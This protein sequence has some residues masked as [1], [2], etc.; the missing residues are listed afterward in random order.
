MPRRGWRLAASGAGWPGAGDLP[1]GFAEAEAQATAYLP[2]RA[3]GPFLALK[4]GGSA[5][6]GTP[7]VQHAPFVGGRTTLRGY[8]WQRY[9]GDA[10]AFG[11]AEVRMPVAPV[12]LLVRWELGVFGL[13][14]T[15]RVWYDGESPGG[16]HTGFGGGVWLRSLGQSIRATYAY[17]EEGRLYLSTGFAF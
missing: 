15:G 2:L 5:V 3:D 7:P 11:S 4:A 13:V 9:R 1:D 6:T 16:W 17:G 12:E 14:D 10:A 8:R